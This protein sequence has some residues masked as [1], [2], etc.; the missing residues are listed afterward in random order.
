MGVVQIFFNVKLSLWNV[1]LNILARSTNRK[2]QHICYSNY[3]LIG[4]QYTLKYLT[5]YCAYLSL[6]V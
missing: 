5:S 4:N 6:P 3:V 1:F 2:V